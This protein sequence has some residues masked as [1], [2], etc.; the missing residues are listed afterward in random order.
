[1]RA[2]TASAF[3]QTRH[4]HNFPPNVATARKKKNINKPIILLIM[5]KKDLIDNVNREW[6]E[7]GSSYSTAGLLYSYAAN[8]FTPQMANA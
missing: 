5:S 3:H 2:P 1:M 4:I 8:H 6:G 7:T